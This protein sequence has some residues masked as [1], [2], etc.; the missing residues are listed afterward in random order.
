LA[1]R[2]STLFVIRVGHGNTRINMRIS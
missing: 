2:V 1:Y